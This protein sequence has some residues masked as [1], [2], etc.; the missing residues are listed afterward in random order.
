MRGGPPTAR[1]NYALFSGAKK[2]RSS[3]ATRSG[4]PVL[5]GARCPTLTSSTRRTRG[6][7]ASRASSVRCRYVGL[8]DLSAGGPALRSR[9]SPG[10]F[11][12]SAGPAVRRSASWAQGRSGAQLCRPHQDLER[13]CSRQTVAPAT[14]EPTA[15]AGAA[16]TSGGFRASHRHLAGRRC[17][18]QPCGSG[19]VR[20]GLHE[21]SPARSSPGPGE[22]CRRRQNSPTGTCP[23]APGWLRALGRVTGQV[24]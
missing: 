24:T 22:R 7:V 14:A 21:G 12:R 15:R 8:S 4:S 16:A 23:P 1:E 10:V 17:D 9:D 6:R 3:P 13:S 19:P 2:R 11:L 20:V 18:G 5:S